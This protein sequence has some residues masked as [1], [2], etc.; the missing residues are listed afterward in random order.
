V[1]ATEHLLVV[2]W[3][4]I[5]P[6]SRRSNYVALT[7]NLAMITRDHLLGPPPAARVATP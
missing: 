4:L 6:C 5:L 7:S 2:P 3:S 1:L